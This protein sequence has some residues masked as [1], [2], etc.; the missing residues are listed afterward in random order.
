[1]HPLFIRRCRVYPA[2]S[3]QR[4]WIAERMQ[5]L[6]QALGAEVL[7]DGTAVS[8]QKKAALKGR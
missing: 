5:G 6:C 4:G 3:A 1:M 2:N 7:T 8:V